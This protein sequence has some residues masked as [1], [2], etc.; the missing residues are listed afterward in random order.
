MSARN[1]TYEPKEE[2]TILMHA[3]HPRMVQDLRFLFLVGIKWSPKLNDSREHKYSPRC[4]SFFASRLCSSEFESRQPM[5][6]HVGISEWNRKRNAWMLRIGEGM[7]KKAF[8]GK[9][10]IAT[11]VAPVDTRLWHV[12]FVL[13]LLNQYDTKS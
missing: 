7:V 10:T 8:V 6:A 13:L 2:N 5:L 11:I 1:Y 12:F 9:K 4:Q 3:V